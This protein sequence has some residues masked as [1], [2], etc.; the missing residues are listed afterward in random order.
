MAG[1]QRV[2]GEGVGFEVDGHDYGRAKGGGSSSS[3]LG[4]GGWRGLCSLGFPS[5]TSAMVRGSRSRTGEA[6]GCERDPSDGGCVGSSGDPTIDMSRMGGDCVELGHVV[7]R[8]SITDW[9]TWHDAV[10]R[11]VPFTKNQNYFLNGAD[12][13]LFTLNDLIEFLIYIY[14]VVIF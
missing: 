11:L 3:L 5:K 9:W 12:F 6:G 13:F 4:L 14:I 1:P 7:P 10:P 8:M 2:A